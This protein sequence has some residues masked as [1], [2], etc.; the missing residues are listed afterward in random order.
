[1]HFALQLAK[2]RVTASETDGVTSMAHYLTAAFVPFDTANCIFMLIRGVWTP[3]P[4][5]STTISVSVVVLFTKHIML[6]I[7]SKRAFEDRAYWNEDDHKLHLKTVLLVCSS[8]T[9]FVAICSIWEAPTG[10]IDG[11]HPV[12][13]GMALLALFASTHTLYPSINNLYTPASAV[14]VCCA[15]WLDWAAPAC[16]I[17]LM[18]IYCLGCGCNILLARVDP[19]A[20]SL[21]FRLL[22]ITPAMVHGLFVFNAMLWRPDWIREEAPAMAVL[23]VDVVVGITA[24]WTVLNAADADG[25]NDDS[26]SSVAF[27]LHEPRANQRQLRASTDG[28]KPN[29]IAG[30]MWCCMW[31]SPITTGILAASLARQTDGSKFGMACCV[32]MVVGLTMLALVFPSN[33]CRAVK[34]SRLACVVYVTLL[35]LIPLL[36]YF[37]GISQ[38]AKAGVVHEERPVSIALVVVFKA[39]IF[40]GLAIFETMGNKGNK[41]ASP[42]A[43]WTPK[44]NDRKN[45]VWLYAVAQSCLVTFSIVRGLGDAD[46]HTSD[47]TPCVHN[48]TDVWVGR[49]SI[50]FLDGTGLT[51]VQCAS[52]FA[53]SNIDG[54]FYLLHL[55]FFSM[56][57][58]EYISQTRGEGH[59]ARRWPDTK[60]ASVLENFW[61][62]VLSAQILYAMLRLRNK[63]DGLYESYVIVDLLFVLILM[64][65]RQ[66]RDGY[67]ALPAFD[68]A[69][70]FCL[71]TWDVANS[72]AIAVVLAHER[73]YATWPLWLADAYVVLCVVTLLTFQISYPFWTSLK[74]LVWVSWINDFI[75][76]C[77]MFI[78]MFKYKL[79]TDSN[80]ATTAFVL[81]ICILSVAVFVWPTKYYA[82]VHLRAASARISG[83][84][85]SAEGLE[86]TLADA[87][88]QESGADYQQ[89]K[90]NLVPKM[91]LLATFIA[92]AGLIV[93]ASA[94]WWVSAF[95]QQTDGSY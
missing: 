46:N 52:K 13:V 11:Y 69:M 7:V 81:N 83:S 55:F 94:D 59:V 2:A 45:A 65:T 57:W 70:M 42:N 74:R 49:A 43:S 27:E 1:M 19:D 62:C 28:L 18:F 32:H 12:C 60:L 41:S 63:M 78:F 25:R 92:S 30:G 71:E 22:Y 37:A 3:W 77:P 5:S 86:A 33:F 44:W 38:Q 16:I 90:S 17:G 61:Q 23:L 8:T 84:H 75:T 10:A 36:Y 51:S 67:G 47:Q 89:L 35:D 58:G 6:T 48:V 95:T 64:L 85:A 53:M 39:L 56:F 54:L 24:S 50:E 80:V 73:E 79:Y 14:F 66:V 15:C 88:G 40:F 29:Q 82:T 21:L 87:G 91:A 9:L 93:S 68:W 4:I 26:S 76:D 34:K 20:K 31:S 72:L